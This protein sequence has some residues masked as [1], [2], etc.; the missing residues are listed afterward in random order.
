[1][2]RPLSRRAAAE[3]HPTPAALRKVQQAI[4]AVKPELPLR[5]IREDASLVRELGMDSLKFAELSI[6]LEDAFGCPVFLDDVLADIEDPGRITV[7]QLARHLEV[8]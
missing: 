6:A 8:P 7:G 3:A 1:M 2:R 4:Q 5:A